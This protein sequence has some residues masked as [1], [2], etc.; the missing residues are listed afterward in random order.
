MYLKLT[1]LDDDL[2]ARVDE[3]VFYLCAD[4]H[5]CGQDCLLGAVLYLL[6]LNR[7]ARILLFSFRG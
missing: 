5:V 3:H 1:T 2:N 6:I 7:A 4:D